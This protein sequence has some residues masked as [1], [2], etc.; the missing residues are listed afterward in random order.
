MQITDTDGAVTSEFMRRD[1]DDDDTRG[2]E[3]S[4][5][6]CDFALWFLCA[7]IIDRSFGRLNDST[8]AV[9][10]GVPL[11]FHFHFYLTVLNI[12]S[13]PFLFFFC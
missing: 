10:A 4:Y 6:T 5:V 9:F 7:I 8:F 12:I 13:H 1:D 11:P 3:Y 2:E